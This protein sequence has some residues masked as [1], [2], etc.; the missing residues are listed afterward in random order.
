[1]GL[2]MK[3][4]IFLSFL[5]FSVSAKAEIYKTVD[6]KGNVIYTD[7]KPRNSES[8][9]VKLK[10]ITPI[11]KAPAISSA[12]AASNS[13]DTAKYYSD[14]KII[15]PLNEATVRNKQRFSVQ[16]FVQPKMLAGHKVR[17]LLDG[18]IVETKRG[19]L[20]TLDDVERGAHTIT[21]ELLDA[22]R[23]VIESSS[24]TIYVHRTT[25]SSP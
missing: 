7:M 24:N 3:L 14:F 19:T 10:P 1:M 4:F 8:E 20:F 13:P 25:V 11:E 17:L 12:P 6:E 18:E 23:R 22:K 15:E 21:A 9:E 16:V 5:I 2:P